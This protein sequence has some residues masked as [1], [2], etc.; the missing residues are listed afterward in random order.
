MK[1]KQR[2]SVVILVASLLLAVT[3][4]DT[5]I[6]F[7]QTHDQTRQAGAYQLESVSGKLESAI[8][9]AE[10]L[11]AE[12]AIKAREYLDD[13]ESLTEF[14]YAAKTKI[15]YDDSGAFNLYIAGSD[16]CII[17]DFDMP[18]DYDATQRVW[19]TGAIKN[20]SIIFSM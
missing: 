11:A 10:G 17:P 8:S 4:M 18:D 1:K 14:I 20:G 3:M 6:L 9:A 13:T 2:L 15:L 12:Y 16:F 19:Y 5:W 7:T